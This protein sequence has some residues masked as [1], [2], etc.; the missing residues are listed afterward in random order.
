MEQKVC[1]LGYFASEAAKKG[2][3]NPN[4]TVNLLEAMK[5]VKDGN[6]QPKSNLERIPENDTVSLH[7]NLK[8]EVCGL[9]HFAEEAAKKGYTNPDG[10]VNLLEAM[11][12]VKD[13]ILLP[14][15]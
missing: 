10:T 11:K 5:N 8:K 13:G 6:I 7:T 4:G 1:G 15:E 12:N 3:T 2:Y 14:K 9:G